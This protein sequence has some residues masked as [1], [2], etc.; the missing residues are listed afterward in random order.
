MNNELSL[1]IF[2]SSP[3]LTNILLIILILQQIL[4]YNKNK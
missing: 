3:I 2:L 1:V 4:P